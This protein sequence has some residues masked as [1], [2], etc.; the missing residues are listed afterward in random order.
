MT[1]VFST[2]VSA[3]EVS[4]AEVLMEKALLKSVLAKRIPPPTMPSE[5]TLSKRILTKDML[6]KDMLIKEMLVKEILVKKMLVKKMSA[7]R[8]QAKTMSAKPDPPET[9]AVIG[10]GPG[11]GATH[12][13]LSAAS[14]LAGG[15]GNKTACVELGVTGAFAALERYFFGSEG[16]GQEFMISGLT[17]VK[18]AASADWVQVINRDYDYVVADMGWDYERIR[19]D[20]LR[21]KRKIVLAALDPWR[22]EEFERFMESAVFESGYREWRYCY[23]FGR[24]ETVRRMERRYG[25]TLW[26]VP[27]RADALRLTSRELEFFYRLLGLES[28][29]R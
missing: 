8:V 7:K 28:C 10:I 3:A 21:C 18:D 23:T 29:R 12:L 19:L 17:Y 6:I 24:S 26:P 4:L 22:E 9:I 5:R 25:I 27:F 16:R 11:C 1:E 20:Y 13:A 15:R 2:E 14:C